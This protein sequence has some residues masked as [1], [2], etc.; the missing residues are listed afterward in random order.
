[1]DILPTEV[2]DLI[3]KFVHNLYMEDLNKQFKNF[4]LNA[5]FYYTMQVY[6]DSFSFNYTRHVQNFLHNLE[7]TEICFRK[8]SCIKYF[9]I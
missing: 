7:F 9:K 2:V 1:M 3:Y 6:R 5:K 4:V 8:P